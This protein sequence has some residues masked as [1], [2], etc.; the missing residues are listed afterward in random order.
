[1][2]LETIAQFLLTL[3]MLVLPAPVLVALARRQSRK[4]ARVGGVAEPEDPEPDEAH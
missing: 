2:D 1:M 4:E 3:A